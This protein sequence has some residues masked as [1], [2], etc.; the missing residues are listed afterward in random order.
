MRRIGLGAGI[1]GEGGLLVDA[2]DSVSGVAKGAKRV[3][4]SQRLGLIGEEGM[5]EY[6]RE[7]IIFFAKIQDNANVR[8]IFSY[9]GHSFGL[10]CRLGTLPARS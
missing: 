3:G 2:S 6:R 10:A 9:L 5:S 8:K 7:D 4:S 1:T